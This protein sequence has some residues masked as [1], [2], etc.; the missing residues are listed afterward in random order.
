MATVVVP[1][2][3]DLLE[4]RQQVRLDGVVFTMLFRFNDRDQSWYLDLLDSSESPI[5]NGIRL[6]TGTPMLRLIATAGRP[7]GEL[8]PIDSTG[9]DTEPDGTNLGT[10]VPLVYVEELDVIAALA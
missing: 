4:Y 2:R 6:R 5:R 10:G 7:A 8:V 3:V 9:A 1:T